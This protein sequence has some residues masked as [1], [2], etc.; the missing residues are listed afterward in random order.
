MEFTVPA[1]AIFVACRP[2][3][4]TTASGNY[5]RFCANVKQGQRRFFRRPR[6]YRWGAV[7]ARCGPTVNPFGHSLGNIPRN[8]LLCN[9]IT[10]LPGQ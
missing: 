4:S 6:I 7:G 2:F 10:P 1:A 8:P 9:H 5:S 3:E